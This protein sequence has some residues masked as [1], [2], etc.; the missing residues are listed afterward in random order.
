[1]R[2]PAKRELV[3]TKTI[4]KWR[5]TLFTRNGT[6]YFLKRSGKK[7]ECLLN[8]G[9]DTAAALFDYNVEC[10]CSTRET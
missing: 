10:V 1:L 2:T 8:F 3:E 7:V 4:G 6:Y 9:T 5:L